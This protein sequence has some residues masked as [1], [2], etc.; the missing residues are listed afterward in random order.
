MLFLATALRQCNGI[1]VK[2][3]LPF[4]GMRL[5]LAFVATASMAHQLQQALSAG[6]QTDFA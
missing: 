2:L 5:N 3:D 1:I 6:T 4:L